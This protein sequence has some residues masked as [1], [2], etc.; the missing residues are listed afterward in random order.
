MDA[1][2]L[3]QEGLDELKERLE[4][5][6]TTGRQEV[7][8]KIKVAREFGDLS[9]NAE[10]DAARNEQAF[11]ESE[12]KSIEDKIQNAVVIEKDSSTHKVAIGHDVVVLDIEFDEE[13]EY[14]IVGTA[15]ANILEN[16]I[17]NESPLGRSLLGKKVGEIVNVQAPNGGT[18]KFKIISI[19]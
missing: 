3:T 12:I 18:I 17:S 14:F 16:R 11:I 5:L 19:K 2:Y 4:Y 1:V 13:I 7:S 6:L 10:Y 8:E 15:E 9:E